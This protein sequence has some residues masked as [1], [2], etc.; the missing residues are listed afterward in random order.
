MSTVSSNSKV[1][2]SILHSFHILTCSP[3]P[4]VRGLSSFLFVFGLTGVRHNFNNATVLFKRAIFLIPFGFFHWVRDVVREATILGDHT[5]AV[6]SG[7]RSGWALFIVSE[8]ILFFAFFWAQFSVSLV[9]IYSV[10]GVL[11]FACRI[12][13]DPWFIP[14]LNTILLLTS[15]RSF[16]TTQGKFLVG[17]YVVALVFFVYTLTCAILFT[18]FQGYEYCYAT[19]SISDGAYGS[20]FYILTGLHGF[21]VFVGTLLLIAAGVRR[22]AHHF[23][24][25][26]AVGFECAGWY[27]H[28][29]DVVWLFL[30]VVLYIPS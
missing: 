24:L 28:F 22:L 21:H 7:L 16:S 27:W 3:W 2:N 14:G 4:S 10:S 9:P 29:V 5:T 13:I 25:N 8:I 26:V 19:F 17:S 1:Q 30:F 23:T 20:C 15:G 12:V 11:R 6:Q 18:A